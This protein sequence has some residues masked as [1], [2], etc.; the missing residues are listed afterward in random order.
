MT[1]EKG[2]QGTDD[3]FLKSG[4]NWQETVR[5]GGNKK[6]TL[7]FCNIKRLHPLY[8]FIICYGV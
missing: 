6:R 4:G 5:I 8:N 1:I 2:G 3:L 7:L